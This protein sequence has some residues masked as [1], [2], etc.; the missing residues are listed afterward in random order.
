MVEGRPN[1]ETQNELLIDLSTKKPQG[2]GKQITIIE[3]VSNF[4]SN[5]SLENNQILSC[6]A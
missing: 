2:S 4:A 6:V 3:I 1:Q 5:I